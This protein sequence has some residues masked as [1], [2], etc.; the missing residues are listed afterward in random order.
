M[1][2]GLATCFQLDITLGGSLNPATTQGIAN[3]LTLILLDGTNM[4]DKVINK[5]FTHPIP[6]FDDVISPTAGL[7]GLRLIVH[8]KDIAATP[9]YQGIDIPTGMAVSAGI[10][11]KKFTHLK[12][13]YTKCGDGNKDELLDEVERKF[14][15]VRRAAERDWSAY[16][17]R[18]CRYN[19]SRIKASS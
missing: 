15:K 19:Q 9:I 2:G 18:E 8:R 17:Q 14:G 6:F 1:H 11:A 13:P 12:K 3:G 4:I 16:S 7:S 5:T 10:K